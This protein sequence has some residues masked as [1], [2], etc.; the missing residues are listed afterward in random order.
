MADFEG[1]DGNSLLNKSQ[2]V[3]GRGESLRNG[4][5]R[6]WCAF[7]FW[8]GLRSSGGELLRNGALR[9]WCAFGFW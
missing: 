6:F 5:L 4:T 9:C 2:A 8:S 1:R 7:G 3:L